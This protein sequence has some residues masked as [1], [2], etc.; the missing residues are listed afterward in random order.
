MIKTLP[1]G[2]VDFEKIEE[3]DDARLA[4]KITPS[5]VQTFASLTGDFNALHMDEGF[6]RKTSFGK[7]VVHGMLSASFVSTLI[8]TLLPGNGALWMSQSLEFLQP[9]FVGDTLH[10]YGRVRKKSPGTRMLVLDI[11]ISNQHRQKIVTGE[12]KV[13][14]LEIVEEK[15]MKDENEKVAL[16]IGGS[17]GIGAA[18]AKRLALGGYQVVVNYVISAE[19]ASRVVSEIETSNG[20]AKAMQADVSNQLEV[21][22]LSAQIKTTLG[23]VNALV[24]CAAPESAL[25]PFEKLSW[26]DI[27]VQLDVQVKGAYN[28]ARAFLPQM[29]EAGSGSMVFVGSIAADG[30]PPANQSDYVLAKSALIALARSLAVEYG[31][32]GI[33]VNVVSPGMTRT[34]RIAKLPE[35]ARLLAKAAAPLRRLAEP[36]EIAETV[37]FLVSPAASHITG[38]TI[39]VAGGMVMQ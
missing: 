31:P 1:N 4:H 8:G 18:V 19:D 15:A 17:R 7:P 23:R 11:E 22:R 36:Q 13:K 34:E 29:V 37:A 3:G 9:V 28:C 10:V 21:E 25:L 16:V 30:I 20:I 38:E 24:F 5:D 33:R 26:E 27:Q 2:I 39:R 12:S 6:A 14:I 35:K 32:K